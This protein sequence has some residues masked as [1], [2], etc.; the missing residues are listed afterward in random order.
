MVLTTYSGF[1]IPDPRCTDQ[2][3][4]FGS[5]ISGRHGAA[6]ALTACRLFGAVYG[7]GVGPT[8]NSYAIPT[9]DKNLI[10]LPIEVIEGYVR[11]F[12]AY[13]RQHTE[14]KFFVT[15]IGC[16][17]AGFTH[18][19]IAPFFRDAPLNCSLPFEWRNL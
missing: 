18:A 17:L 5:N 3:Y 10:P 2:R 19:E 9:K 7:V 6:S 16:G 4:V 11:E 8:G 12:K 1:V 14:L 15:T 13:A